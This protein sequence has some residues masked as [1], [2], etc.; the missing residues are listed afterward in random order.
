MLTSGDKA[1]HP[2][3]NYVRGHLA[4]EPTP[5]SDWM[6]GDGADRDIHRPIQDP[7]ASKG[8]LSHAKVEFKC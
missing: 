3:D 2:A 1:V 8:Q 6:G 7:V 5:Q 4:R